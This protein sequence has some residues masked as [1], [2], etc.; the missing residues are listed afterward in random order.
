MVV[1]VELE[2]A[3]FVASITRFVVFVEV[4]EPK[5]ADEVL[6]AGVICCKLAENSIAYI[7][8]SDELDSGIYR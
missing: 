1:W 3:K 5:F 4:D 6:T 8:I 2:T 7:E